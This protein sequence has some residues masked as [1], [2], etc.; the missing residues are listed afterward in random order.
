MPSTQGISWDTRSSRHFHHSPCVAP[1]L[2]WD[3]SR[4]E[5]LLQM[6]SAEPCITVGKAEP[7]PPALLRWCLNEQLICCLLL[8]A[9]EKPGHGSLGKA[10]SMAALPSQAQL[11]FMPFLMVLRKPQGG[12]RSGEPAEWMRG[13]LVSSASNML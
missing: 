4:P 10:V 12:G 8:R 7:E 9:R 11:Q 1:T 3:L 13:A 2:S 5:P 6:L